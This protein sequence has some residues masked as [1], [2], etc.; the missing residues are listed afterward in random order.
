M[1]EG[2]SLVEESGLSVV[3]KD[4]INKKK[5]DAKMNSISVRLEQEVIVYT[6]SFLCIQIDSK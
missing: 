2:G 4:L 3:E 6:H 1:D 5:L